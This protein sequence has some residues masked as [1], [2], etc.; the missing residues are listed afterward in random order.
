KAFPNQK[1]TPDS[2]LYTITDLSRVWIVADVFESDVTSIKVGDQAY[3]MFTSGG[4]PPIAAKVSYIQPQVDPMTRTLKVRLDAGNPGLRMK[5]EMFVNV[6][7]G[8][9]SPPQLTVPTEAVLDAG[10]RQT[11]FV[12]LGNGYL[13]PRRVTAGERFGDRV[14][15]LRGL[16]VGERVV[17]SGTFLVDSESQLKAAANGM[18]APTHQHGGSAT[19][20]DAKK[21]PTPAP[22]ADPHKG[23]ARD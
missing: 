13:E 21:Q 17:S 18:G 10:D 16:S 14:T 20:P 4:V 8:V 3:V 12:D 1:V 6:E 5:P 7:F 22:A 15:I 19:A 23:H 9:V 2:D 11:V